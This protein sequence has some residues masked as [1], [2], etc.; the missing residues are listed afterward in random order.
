MKCEDR[1]TPQRLSAE[2]AG[3]WT[4]WD[5]EQKRMVGSGHTFEEAKQVAADAGESSVILAKAP[6][7]SFFG[8][9]RRWS[10]VVA[11]FISL[12]PSISGSMGPNVSLQ[13]CITPV[14]SSSD[15]DNAADEQ[16]EFGD[17]E[18]VGEINE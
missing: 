17:S 6:S 16:I 14:S 8:R 1:F 7:A 3:L 4:V 9:A 13:S 15:T 12:V 18:H 5:R 10:Q 11:V 2:F